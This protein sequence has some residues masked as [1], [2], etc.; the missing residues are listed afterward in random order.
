MCK[1]V[2]SQDR[3]LNISDDENPWERAS[4]T[5]VEGEGAL[6]IRADGRVVD[7]DEC[8]WL[9]GAGVVRGGRGNDADFGAGVDKKMCI[10][11]SVSYVE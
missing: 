11:V 5:E 9:E 8:V 2:S 6:S 3:F 10:V 4:N 7:S 1:E